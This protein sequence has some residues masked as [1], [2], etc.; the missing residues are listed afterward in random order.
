MALQKQG[1]YKQVKRA[2]TKVNREKIGLDVSISTRKILEIR[3]GRADFALAESVV[4]G[5]GNI[6]RSE[7]EN[8]TMRELGAEKTQTVLASAPISTGVSFESV[9]GKEV[10]E[11]FREE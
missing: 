4:T 1:T 3:N 7:I 11:R 8:N 2:I 10:R 9:F 5:A 6:S